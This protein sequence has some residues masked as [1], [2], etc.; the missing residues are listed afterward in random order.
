M[1]Y[2]R[3]LIRLD[4]LEQRLGNLQNTIEDA[5]DESV[6]EALQTIKRQESYS[7]NSDAAGIWAVVYDPPFAESP[8]VSVELVNPDEHTSF[9]I[10]ATT[11]AG[12]SVH[13]FRR[14]VINILGLQVPSFTIANAAGQA[15]T[16]VA[17]QR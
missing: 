3:R 6:D 1:N 10:I 4:F 8:Y 7:G 16:A 13:V 5:I 14:T 9:R 11:A 12:F 15:C 2:W 17:F